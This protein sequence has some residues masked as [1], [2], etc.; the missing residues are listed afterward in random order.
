MCTADLTILQPLV[1]QGAPL[2][3]KSLFLR[4]LSALLSLDAT[5]VLSQ[6]QPSFRFVLQS[7]QRL[8]SSTDPRE[9]GL[10]SQVGSRNIPASC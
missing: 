5:A 2:E 3:A 9:A 7:Y 4:L 8:L 6:L 1:T 10:K